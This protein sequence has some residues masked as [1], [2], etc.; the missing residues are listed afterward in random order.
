MEGAKTVEMKAMEA[1]EEI[2]KIVRGERKVENRLEAIED[3]LFDY[4]RFVAVTVSSK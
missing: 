3:L 1:L 2:R 4:D